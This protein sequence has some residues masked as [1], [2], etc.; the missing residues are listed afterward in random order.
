MK[1]HYKLFIMLTCFIVA[2]S[3]IFTLLT[4]LVVQETVQGASQDV[5]SEELDVLSGL[6]LQHYERNGQ[7]WTGIS[8]LALLSHID[9][10]LP[11]GIVIT[12]T[13]GEIVLHEGDEPASVIRI[14]GFH[15]QLKRDGEQF[16]NLY[17]HDPEVAYFSK[18]RIGIPI[19]VLTLLIL[20]AIV[21][22]AVSLMIA[23]LIARRL[24]APLTRLIP[25][26]ERMGRGELGLQAPGEHQQDEYGRVAKSFN[27][28]SRMLQKSEK[29]RRNLVADIAHELRTPLTII[30]GKLELAQHGGQPVD[31][32]KLLPV[33]DELIRLTKLVDDLNLISQAEV[34][35]LPLEKKPVDLNR[36]LAQIVERV[37]EDAGQ[38][39]ITVT[40]DGQPE[41]PRAHVDP[42][43]ISQVFL[44]LLV[45]AIRYTPENGL[46][47]LK[48]ESAPA[49]GAG[50]GAGTDTVTGGSGIRVTVS[51]TG[52]GIEPEHLPHIFDRFYRTDEG[53]SRNSGGIGL[54]LA[55]AKGII[56]AHHGTITAESEVGRGTTF[57]VTLPATS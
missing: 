12:D 3:L 34:D 33:Q 28:M 52:P 53:R 10:D 16:G 30:R 1:L 6:I 25:I 55:I 19:S 38:K 21:F 41:L 22:I 29:T 32:V 8:E 17:Y 23:Y 15:R 13:D 5:R 50:A 54:G 31:P 45:N 46:V 4:Y 49:A 20:N 14:L 35:R 27:Q 9:T 26:L 39:A 51:D 36:L 37:S 43:R 48:T 18:L 42:H 57:I 47:T 2:M 44:N 24:T 11:T 56:E 7:S 40:F